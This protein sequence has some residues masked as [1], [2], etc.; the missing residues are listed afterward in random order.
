M[1]LFV[2]VDFKGEEVIMNMFKNIFS[3]GESVFL[4]ITHRRNRY[5][6]KINE[7]RARKNILEGL[8]E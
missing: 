4:V 7:S 8:D 1:T 2:Y 3:S 5:L 6:N